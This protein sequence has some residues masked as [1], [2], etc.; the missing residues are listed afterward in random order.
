MG[1][2][3]DPSIRTSAVTSPPHR[4]SD[5]FGISVHGSGFIMSNGSTNLTGYWNP[6]GVLSTD[7]ISPSPGITTITS[8]T[9]TNAL[10]G[11][12]SISPDSWYKV[13][14]IVERVANDRFDTRVEVWPSNA[15]GTLR[16]DSS[17]LAVFEINGLQNPTI[18]NSSILKSYVNFSGYRFTKFDDYGV[19]LSGG[20][21]V[22]QPGNPVVLTTQAVESTTQISFDGAVTADGGAPVTERGFVYSV[23]PNPTTS[24]SKVIIGTGIGDFTGTSSSVP[25][26]SY[27]VRAYAINANGISYGSEEQVTFVSQISGQPSVPAATVDNHLADT[28]IDSKVPLGLL[29][30]GLLLGGISAFSGSH[31]L[32]Q[33]ASRKH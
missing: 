31:T 19:E 25:Y 29:G 5:A 13:V 7:G 30:V 18:L 3:A 12:S 14:F 21:S 24:D 4:P 28:G 32:R 22:I 16:D 27:F 15:D 26:G 1:F 10:F 11:N 6:A 8:L 2:S 20:V 9:G 17:A 33:K 23:N